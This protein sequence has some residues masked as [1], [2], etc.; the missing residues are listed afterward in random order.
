MTPLPGCQI[1]IRSQHLE[2]RLWN[3]TLIMDCRAQ[4]KR[5]EGYFLHWFETD[6]T[7]C[8]LTELQWNIQMCRELTS[9]P[10]P[11]KAQRSNTLAHPTQPAWLLS[12]ISS[13]QESWA[14]PRQQFKV[15]PWALGYKRWEQLCT[16]QNLGSTHRRLTSLTFQSSLHQVL[17]EGGPKPSIISFYMPWIATIA[18]ALLPYP[19]QVDFTI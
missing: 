10:R 2:R 11:S 19:K 17:G 18:M 3:V 1:N 12:W 5:W 13:E 7:F 15:F 16:R 8:T 14:H 6:D 9:S 4:D